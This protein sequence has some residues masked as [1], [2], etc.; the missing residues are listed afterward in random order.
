MTMIRFISRL[1]ILIGTI[2]HVRSWT[3]TP[4]LTPKTATPTNEPPPTVRTPSTDLGTAGHRRR[5]FLETSVVATVTAALFHPA[6]SHASYI[7][8]AID[9]PKITRRV[10]LDVAYGP[11]GGDTGR[12]V[13]GLYGDIMPKTT[14]NF[15]KL[16]ASSAYAGTSFYRVISDF[17]IQGGAVGDPTGKTGR[18]SFEGGGP[19]EPDNFNVKHTK[20]GLLSMV[21]GLDG[22]V[23][24]RFFV[25]TKDGAGWADDRYAAFGIVEEGLDVVK[26]IEKVPVSPP[27]NSPKSEVKIVASGL[28]DN[29]T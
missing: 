20:V 10:Y 28:L 2:T 19:F 25:N 24:S 3:P 12:L 4:I 15:E 11:N 29:A 27:K 17:S 9:S 16:C 5:D 22:A 13:I 21:R 23:D 14:D 26:S 7:D 1:P 6:P 8:P 18:S